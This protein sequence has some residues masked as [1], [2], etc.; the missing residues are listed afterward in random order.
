MNKSACHHGDNSFFPEMNG[1]LRSLHSL[2]LG[3]LDDLHSEDLDAEAV[4]QIV[5]ASTFLRTTGRTEGREDSRS[6]FLKGLIDDWR[7][8]LDDKAQD[9]VRETGGELLVELGYERS[10]NW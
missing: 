6:H 2:A 4:G 1:L 5:D 9:F 7:N 10:L 8:H 3:I